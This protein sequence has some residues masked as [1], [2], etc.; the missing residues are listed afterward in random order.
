MLQINKDEFIQMCKLLP[1]KQVAKQLGIGLSTVCKYAKM[2]GVTK[3]KV[4]HDNRNGGRPKN[5]GI[6][7]VD[8]KEINK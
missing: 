6:Q 5:S 4:I 2:F 7:F 8:I 1:Y 3:Q